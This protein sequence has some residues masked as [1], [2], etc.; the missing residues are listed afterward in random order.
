MYLMISREQ[1]IWGVPPACWIG[2]G[3][4]SFHR[5]NQHFTNDNTGPRT[6][7]DMIHIVFVISGHAESQRSFVNSVESKLEYTFL[8][9]LSIITNSIKRSN[10]RGFVPTGSYESS[11]HQECNQEQVLN[12]IIIIIVISFK[13]GHAWPVPIQNFNF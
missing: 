10:G 5:K 4:P 9:Q 7:A 3:V 12:F 8:L 6:W 1:S 13:V 2:G 11:L